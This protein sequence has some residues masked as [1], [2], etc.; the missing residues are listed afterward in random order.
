MEYFCNL[1]STLILCDLFNEIFKTGNW[2]VTD[3]Q[4]LLMKRGP[5]PLGN[6]V[7]SLG[8]TVMYHCVGL[9]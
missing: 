4:N 5:T 2:G 7:V 9:E 3:T 1:R 6:N 8:K